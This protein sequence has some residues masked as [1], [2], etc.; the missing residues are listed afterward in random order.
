MIEISQKEF[1]A[2]VQD[3]IDGKTTRVKLTKELKILYTILAIVCTIEVL[4]TKPS[5][6]IIKWRKIWQKRMLLK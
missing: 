1:E 6:T 2:K 3:I 4:Y 5:K